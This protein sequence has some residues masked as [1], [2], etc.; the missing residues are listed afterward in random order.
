MWRLIVI[1][2]LLVIVYF[3]VRSAVRNLFGKGRE[4]GRVESS[5][6][7]S[8]LVQDPVCGMYVAREGAF[9]VREAERTWFFCS[10]A[11]RAAYQQKLKSV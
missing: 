11:C 9:F 4:A 1:T 6:P 3:M 2:I 7:S 5:G 8:E 10:D